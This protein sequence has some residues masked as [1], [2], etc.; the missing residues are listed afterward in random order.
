MPLHVPLVH[1]SLL[2]HALPSSHVVPLVRLLHVVVELAGV[3]TRQLLTGFTAPAGMS[4]PP[5]KHCEAQLPAPH[6]W[7]LA[8]PVPSGKL[9]WAQ[10]PL[11]SQAS[12]VQALPSLVQAPPAA[13]LACVQPEAGLQPSLVHGFVSSQ[14]AAA[15]PVQVPA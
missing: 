9:G 7:P 6:T 4:A 13:T 12:V 5:M 15:P 8:Q 14:F 2:E 10:V 3:H 1:T 11:P